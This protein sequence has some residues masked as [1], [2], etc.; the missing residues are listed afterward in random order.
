[1]P[2]FRWRAFANWKELAT[3]AEKTKMEFH[4]FDSLGHT[5][6]IGAFF[7][8]GT[9]PAGHKAIFEYIQRQ[10]AKKTLQ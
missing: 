4:Y 8:K 10:A 9:L 7:T 1:M 6:G 2:M 3:T 5:L